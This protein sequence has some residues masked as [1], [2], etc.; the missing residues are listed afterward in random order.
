MPREGSLKISVII[1]TL[2]EG[3][4]IGETLSVLAKSSKN[5][6]IIVVDGGSNDE[7]V[8]IA[9]KFTDK[10]YVFNERGI[11]RARNHGACKAS[12]DILIFMDADVQP[13]T[14]FVEKILSAFRDRN[15]VGVTCNVMPRDPRPPEAAFFR[16][17]NFLLRFF[18]H[19]KPH[20]RGEFFA[21]RREAFLKIGGFNENLPCIEDHDL[22]LRLSK[23]GK[24][25]FLKNLTVYESMRRF[26][27]MGFLKVLKLWISNYIF[28]LLFNR[29]IS[30]SW[31]PVR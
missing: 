15:V 7:T 8:D 27:Q 14:D 31:K 9:K 24:I 6:E 21:V 29:T 18:A 10:V 5:L 17:Y 2:Q 12:G 1:P 23:I 3:N 19:F 26:R 25:I 13:S 16:F 11:G 20:S 28:Y 4:Y 22:A 30:S